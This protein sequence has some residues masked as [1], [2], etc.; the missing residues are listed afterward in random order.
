MCPCMPAVRFFP[1][2]CGSTVL[3]FLTNY[4]YFQPSGNLQFGKAMLERRDQIADMTPAEEDSRLFANGVVE[5]ELELTPLRKESSRLDL[6]FVG[7]IGSSEIEIVFSGR[8]RAASAPLS[9]TL[10]RLFSEAAKMSTKPQSQ[11]NT[12]CDVRV[13]GSWR[14]NIVEEEG[15]IE[16]RYQ[17]L[18]ARWSYSENEETERTY[19]EVPINQKQAQ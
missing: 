19:G 9:A 11:H 13:L 10:D 1:L 2:K 17:F 3:S 6:V 15:M 18:V 5:V 12:R 8:R 16:R 4:R 14:K 7:F